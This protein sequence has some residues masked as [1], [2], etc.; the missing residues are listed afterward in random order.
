MLEQLIPH[1]SVN[2][3][4]DIDDDALWQ[5]GIRGIITDLDNTL[6]GAKAP[7]APEELIRWLDRLRSLGFRIV[8]VSNNRKSR[9]VHFAESLELPFI[10]RAK[11]PIR[12]AFQRALQIIGTE[13]GQTVMIGDQMLTDVL[14]GN[15]MGMRTILVS[16]I[17]P[18]DEGW[19][20]RI[21]RRLE[22]IAIYW[23]K[24][25]GLMPWED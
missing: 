21:N 11:K 23:M 6:V 8:I 14:G 2:H 18:A 17:S 19:T 12:S 7:V 4:Y 22:K 16:P 15:R 24:K 3:I 5:A 1:L 10:F 20:T 13:A 25:K 9:V